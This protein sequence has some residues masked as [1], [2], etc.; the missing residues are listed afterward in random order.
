[1]R[2]L[3]LTPLHRIDRPYRRCSRC[4]LD[5]EGPHKIS[6]DANGI[7]NFCHAY[8]EQMRKSYLPPEVRKEKFAAAIAEI[9]ASG[10][11]RRYDCIMGLSGGMDSS[12]IAYL[13]MV[14]GL[15]PLIVH[16]DN[17]WDA[18]LAVKNIENIIQ[19]TGFD[20]Y[21]YVVD[22]EE[23]KDMQL[24]YLKA[25]VIDVEVVSDQAIFAL[26]H[27]VADRLGIRHILFGDNPKTERTMPKGWG[28]HK[29]DLANMLAIHR[30]FG[31]KKIKSYPL[32]GTYDLEWYRRLRGIRYVSLLH[33]TDYSVP[34]VKAILEREFG[35]R[36]Y[37]W[38]HCESVFTRFYQGY[39]LPRKNNVD[40]RKAHL[41]D[42]ILSG[43][44]TREEGLA[45]LNLPYYKGDD[46]QEDY[47]FTVRKFA[48]T[49]DEFEAI[50]AKPPVPH[51]S[52]PMDK[53]DLSWR[54]KWKLWRVWGVLTGLFR[55]SGRRL[56]GGRAWAGLKRGWLRRIETNLD[57]ALGT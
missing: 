26:L 47:D 11:G 38:K 57:K 4:L 8:H 22:W 10:E 18:E 16:L 49:P 51:E 48:L 25:S 15:R 5:T 43:Q 41:S 28:F 30:R 53:V 39:I 54:V 40:K 36:D 32:M 33:Y 50:L 2:T 44:I 27:I 3:D 21:N 31:T 45:R 13:A 7:C 9:K 42:Q 52:F 34:E 56:V 29:N 6:F 14:N 23:F 20:Y 1:M 12:F 19:R 46:L 24:A 37:R 35:W 55:T 17:G